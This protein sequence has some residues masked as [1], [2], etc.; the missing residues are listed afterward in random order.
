MKS[1]WVEGPE[2]F[3]PRVRKVGGPEVRRSKGSRFGVL[4]LRRVKGQRV[5]CLKSLRADGPEGRRYDW[6]R[7][8]GDRSVGGPMG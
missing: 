2:F 5:E 8:F 6:S 3:K 4:S 7:V 1:Q